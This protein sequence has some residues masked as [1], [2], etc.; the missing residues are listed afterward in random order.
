MQRRL[1]K[2]FQGEN[3]VH[4]LAEESIDIHRSPATVFDYVAN[5]ERFGEWFPGVLSIESANDMAHGDVGKQYLET[6]TVPLRGKRRIR[7]LVQQA[8]RNR[9]FVTEGN[10][11]PIMPRMEVSITSQSAESCRLT[12]RMFSRNKSALFRLTLLPLARGVMRKRAAV[13]MKRLK[14]NLEQAPPGQQPDA[15][16]S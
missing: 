10:L 9:L 16:N 13:G 7:L 14:R 1:E 2:Y 5:M 15:A 6:V 3:P 4:L 12:W 8:E 11:P